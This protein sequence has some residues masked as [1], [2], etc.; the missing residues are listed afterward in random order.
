MVDKSAWRVSIPLKKSADSDMNKLFALKTTIK[1][2]S[3]CKLVS[4]ANS[5]R[6]LRI[7]FTSG[8]PSWQHGLATINLPVVIKSNDKTGQAFITTVS[9]YTQ[10]NYTFTRREVWWF[11]SNF[12]SH[13]WSIENYLIILTLL[14]SKPSLE[15]AFFW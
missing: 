7:A 1:V 10:P 14:V 8:N 11:Y 9:L 12:Y 3:D 5:W 13:R 2:Y 15:D 6:R 4:F